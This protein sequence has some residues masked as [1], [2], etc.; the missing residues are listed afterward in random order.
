VT[1]LA[2]KLKSD[3]RTQTEIAKLVGTS[4]TMISLYANGLRVPP[5][6]LARLSDVL[7]CNPDELVGNAEEAAHV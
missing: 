5:D 3:P 7:D 6:V 2:A 1:N 4:Q